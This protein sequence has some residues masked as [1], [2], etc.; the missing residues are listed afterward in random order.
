MR[1]EDSGGVSA[2]AEERRVTESDDAG[3]AER[4]IERQREQDHDQHVG[5]N[6]EIAAGDEVEDKCECPRQQ[7]PGAGEV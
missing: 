6:A 4:E 5:A 1:R 2:E 3:L 7:M